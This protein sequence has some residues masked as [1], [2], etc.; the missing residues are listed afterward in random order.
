MKGCETLRRRRRL[1]GVQPTGGRRQARA[2]RPGS[3]EPAPVCRPAA[4]RAVAGTWSGRSTPTCAVVVDTKLTLREAL[5]MFVEREISRKD[6]RRIE[7]ALKI[8]RFRCAISPTSTSRPSRASTGAKCG[9]WRRRGGWRTADASS[10]GLEPPSPPPSQKDPEP[11]S[12]PARGPAGVDKHKGVDARAGDVVGPAG[13]GR[14]RVETL[15]RKLAQHAR[16]LQRAPLQELLQR[17]PR[18]AR[19]RCRTRGGRLRSWC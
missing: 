19:R 9:S 12:E 6:E 17:T 11:P 14:H 1:D 3:E 5:A 10:L 13:L 8:A 2:L 16:R 15:P 7:M 4:V 18:P